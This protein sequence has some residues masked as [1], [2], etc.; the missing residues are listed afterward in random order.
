MTVA[1]SV[2]GTV[3]LRGSCDVEEAELLLQHLL[4]TSAASINWDGCEWAHTAV[5]QVLLV[6]RAVPSGTPANTFLRDYVGPLLSR[7]AS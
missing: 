1:I 4:A 6:A 7:S 3:E 2:N 5:I